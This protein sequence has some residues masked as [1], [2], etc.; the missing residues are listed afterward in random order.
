MVTIGIILVIGFL[1]INYKINFMQS[2][3]DQILGMLAAE[4]ARLVGIKG[5]IDKIISEHEQP[6]GSIDAAGVL[7]IQN[8]ILGNASDVDAIVAELPAEETPPPATTEPPVVTDPVI[9][10]PVVET[11][12]P[13]ITAPVVTEPTSTQPVVT[14]SPVITEA[15]VVEAPS[16]DAPVVTEPVVETPVVTEQPAGTDQQQ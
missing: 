5:G 12:A 6:D 16:T 10:A 15:P 2:A 9:V 11:P 3:L 8:A 14:E 7:R 4:K 13:V 1:F